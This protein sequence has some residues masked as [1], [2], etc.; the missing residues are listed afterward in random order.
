ASCPFS[1]SRRGFVVSEGAGCIVI[2]SRAF[3][4]AHGLA[5]AAELAG[6][7]MSA[8]AFHVVAPNPVTVTRC[9]AES[10]RHAGITP[11][12]I[13]AVNAHAAS[14]KVG[15]QVE[16]D[17]LQE[18]F[19]KKIPPVSANKSQLGH[20]MGATSAL[21]SILALEGMRRGVLL[22]TINHQPDP[23]IELDCVSEGARTCPQEFVLKNA[24]GFGGCNA[25]LVFRRVA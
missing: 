13:D 9:M 21:E 20:A 19:G 24:F 25:C 1:P 11:A 12:E 10:I 3:A 7:A 6:W 14:T 8:D 16:A 18:I 17:A 4:A 2:A 22:P 15:D 5:F 23:A